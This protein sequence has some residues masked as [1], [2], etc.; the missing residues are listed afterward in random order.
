MNMSRY[1]RFQMINTSGYIYVSKK[2]RKIHAISLYSGH[3]RIVDVVDSEAKLLINGMI[4]TSLR[5]NPSEF[6]RL[7]RYVDRCND[8]FISEVIATFRGYLY[9]EEFERAIFCYIG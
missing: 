6:Y 9:S 3:L 5:Q 2:T 1:E 7:M 4:L 8:P